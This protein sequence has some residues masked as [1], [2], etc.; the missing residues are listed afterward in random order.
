[1]FGRYII[2]L[3]SPDNFK[4]RTAMTNLIN[5]R[6]IISEIKHVCGRLTFH[7]SV[8]RRVTTSI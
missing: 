3:N 1:M 2:K 8:Q 6:Q 7:V 5:I 4:R